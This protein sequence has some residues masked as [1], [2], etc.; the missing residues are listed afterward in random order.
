M[1]QNVALETNAS[2]KNMMIRVLSELDE[3]NGSAKIM[4]DDKAPVELLGMKVIDDLIKDEVE[5]YKDIY[6]K[7]GFDGLKDEL[8]G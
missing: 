6:R 8:F 1:E 5:Y 4:T 7:E 3:Y 2:L